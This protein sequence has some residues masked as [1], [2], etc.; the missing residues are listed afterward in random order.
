M[1]FTALKS[2]FSSMLGIISLMIVPI[3]VGG[4]QLEH[5]YTIKKMKNIARELKGNDQYLK[6][7]MKEIKKDV[8]EVK[9]DV[10]DTL[11]IIIVNGQYTMQ[12]ING[13]KKLM[14]EWLKRLEHCQ[15]SGV[16]YCDKDK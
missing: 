2:A 15:K 9:K 3:H 10:E 11:S 7:N 5:W 14:Q 16:K 6:E 13:D 1:V 12:A 8:K 4:D